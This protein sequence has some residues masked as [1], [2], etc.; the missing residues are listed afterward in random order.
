[1][2]AGK[3]CIF[4]ELKRV[5]KSRL[6]AC[7]LMMIIAV[8]AVA[9][10][11]CMVYAEGTQGGTADTVSLASSKS[12]AKATVTGLKC[13][14]W[15]GRP[16]TQKPV[17]KL[18]SRKLKAGTDYKISYKS[19]VNIGR[20]TMIIR[21]RGKYSGT[22]TKTFIIK[23]R[24][25]ALVNLKR[26]GSTMTVTWKRQTKQISGYQ[27]TYSAARHPH[28]SPNLDR[29]RIKNARTTSRKIKI[30]PTAYRYRV[31]IRTYKKIG[32]NY[33]FSDWSVPFNIWKDGT[34]DR[35][36]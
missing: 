17:V 36:E 13:R 30:A 24:P 21:G 5:S 28:L 20:A 18:G 9:S 3:K 35:Y 1:M 4:R 27:I 6:A 31:W 19:N 7:F 32:S 2:K 34:L 26:R 15:T 25:T 22:I 33:Y 16:L 12:I 14:T 29:I 10:Y 8:S 11:P 23:P